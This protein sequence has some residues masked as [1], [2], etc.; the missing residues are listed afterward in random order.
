MLNTFHLFLSMCFSKLSATSL[1]N[2]QGSRETPVEPFP[3]ILSLSNVFNNSSSLPFI[4]LLKAT[5]ASR[6]SFLFFFYRF[7]PK[8]RRF[9]C[10][11]TFNLTKLLRATFYATFTPPPPLPTPPLVYINNIHRRISSTSLG[12]LPPS[13]PDPRLFT[14]LVVGA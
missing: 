8:G 9:C 3:P 11:S 12:C 10:R 4:H 5:R 13:L 6:V 1:K 14:T 2:Q 7:V